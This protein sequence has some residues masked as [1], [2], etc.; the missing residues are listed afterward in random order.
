VDE[1]TRDALDRLEGHPS[2]YVR[3]RI[4]LA[5]GRIVETY[6]LDRAQVAGRPRITTGDWRRQGKGNRRQMLFSF[7]QQARRANYVH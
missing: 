3:T 4:R 1:R 2:F 7:E 5:N 6:L